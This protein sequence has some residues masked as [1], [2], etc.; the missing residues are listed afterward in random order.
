MP[1]TTPVSTPAESTPT[2][3]AMAIQKSNRVTRYSRRSSVTSIIPNTTASMITARED[4]LREVGEERRE[5][6]Q[7]Q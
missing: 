2:I 5:E 3:A 4:R 7:R 6:E 1:M